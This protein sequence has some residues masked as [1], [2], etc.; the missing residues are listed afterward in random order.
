MSKLEQTFSTTVNVEAPKAEGEME[1]TANLLSQA[2]PFARIEGDIEAPSGGGT[3]SSFGDTQSNS[4]QSIWK[5]SS[6]PVAL[7]FHL[8]FR[9]AAL[10]VYLFGSLFISNFPFIFITCVLLLSFDF[11]T[12]KN[13]TG[14]LL[15]G[16]RW[17]NDIQEDGK[18]VWMFESRDPSRPVNPTDSRIFWI[19]LY[20]TFV[21]WAICGFLSLIRFD[22]KWLLIV[23]VA[24]T[25]NFANVLGY[26]QCDKDAKRK[27]AT[28]FASQNVG[29]VG[30]LFSS[31]VGRVFS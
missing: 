16:L 17:W 9:S 3:N 11:W 7:G 25:L 31:G 13:V 2:G 22:T 18:N 5:Q 29:W 24:L 8:F 21:L 23:A 1:S 26:T 4:N 19:S 10:L 14:R 15:V 12:V 6:H 20:V 27:W 30:K 28:G